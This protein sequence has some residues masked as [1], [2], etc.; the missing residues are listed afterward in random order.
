MA[1]KLFHPDSGDA[2]W[3]EERQFSRF[4]AWVDVLQMTA[5]APR[6]QGDAE[7]SRGE[8]V[9]SLRTLSRRWKWSVKKVRTWILGG[10]NKGK[11]RAQREAQ[12]GTVYLVVNYDTYQRG[13]GYEG[14]PE[15][16]QKGTARAQQGHKK[17]S[18]KAITTTTHGESDA[19][20]AE[21]WAEYPKR[22]GNS[23]AD[24]Y[25]RWL[26]RV[27]EGV[28][29]LTMLEGTRRY[30]RY[31]AAN[32]PESPRYIK[33]AQTF[34]GR[35][36]HFDSDWAGGESVDPRVARVLSIVEEEDAELARTRALLAKRGAA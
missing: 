24:T 29:P 14:T 13:E 18:S 35:G 9:A 11:L 16:T 30:A 7:L 34:F 32:P 27:R 10:T 5:W 6:R 28:D 31:I 33:Q 23:K 19:V 2:D 25:Q 8:F 12:A 36:K 20:F 3:L 26:A 21:A 1:R 4:E 22:P 15:E 17:E